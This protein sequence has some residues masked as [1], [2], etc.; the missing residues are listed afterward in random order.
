M[1][2]SKSKYHN[3]KTVMLGIEF[4]SKKE[5]QRYFDLSILLKAGQITELKRQV[6]FVVCPKVPGVKGSKE[7]KYIADFVYFEN[8]KHVIEDVKSPITKKNPVYS[9]K[10]QLVQFNYPDYEFREY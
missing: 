2:F 1:K 6:S 4:D 8:G 7:R 5:A 10:K 3:V 9:L